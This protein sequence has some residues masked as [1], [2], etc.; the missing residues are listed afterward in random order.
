M[1]NFLE[2]IFAQLK[3]ADGR[4]VLREIRGEQFVGVTGS[5]LLEQVGKVR[6]FLRSSGILPGERCALLAPQS[7]IS[8]STHMAMMPTGLILVP[9]YS[10][11]SHAECS[12]RL[13]DLPP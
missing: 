8:L 4:V 1:P 10:R 9:L 7:I 6:V 11:A 12:S 5:E 2:N 3:R 13:E